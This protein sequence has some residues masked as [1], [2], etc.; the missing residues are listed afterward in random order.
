MLAPPHGARVLDLCCGTG[1]LVFHLLRIDPTL[2]VTGIDFCA[3]ML[4]RARE[5]ARRIAR[6]NAAFVEGDVMSLPFDDDTFDGA[7]MGF[8]C[9]T[10]STSTACC[11]RSCAYSSPA[12][13]SST[14]T[15]AKRRTALEAAL[16]SLLLRRRP[17]GRRLVGGSREAYTYLPNSLTHHP[18]ASELR[19]RFARA[20][21]ADAGYVPLVG[22]AIA[23]HYGNETVSDSSLDGA[24]G[25]AAE[26]TC[27]G[28][29]R[30]FSARR[31]R[32]TT[33]SSPKR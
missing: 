7:T 23:V 32:P 5:R 13:A 9:A 31:F 8:C 24:Y 25:G 15:S 18:N 27:T 14:S 21:F 1:D 10:S 20:G 3:P 4:E 22:G 30:P 17:A 19:D 11:A 12:R 28:W 6:G 26:P 29:S 2:D 33:R 16:R